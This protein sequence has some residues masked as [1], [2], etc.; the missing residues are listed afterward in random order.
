[1]TRSYAVALALLG[2]LFAVAYVVDRARRDPSDLVAVIESAGRAGL[3]CQ[4]E[5]VPSGVVQRVFLSARPLTADA[6]A[7][8]VCYRPK[9][10]I[11]ACYFPG[12]RMSY[13]HYPRHSVFWGQTYLTGDP[14][15]IERLTGQKLP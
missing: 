14:A 6:T 1:M 3:Y 7:D 2:C 11:V 12:A 13:N 10:G 9:P 5:G 8:V 15:L 4:V